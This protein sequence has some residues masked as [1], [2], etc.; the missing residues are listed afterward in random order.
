VAFPPAEHWVRRSSDSEALFP[1][2]AFHNADDTSNEWNQVSIS[3]SMLNHMSFTEQ[4]FSAQFP[5]SESEMIPEHESDFG[6]AESVESSNPAA[7]SNIPNQN[8]PSEMSSESKEHAPQ[9]S[10]FPRPRERRVDLAARRKR[11]RPAAIGTAGLSSSLRGPSS[12]SPTTRMPH[13][14]GLPLRH[15]KSTQNFSSVLSPR[16]PGIR[17]VSAS[18]RSPL[19]IPSSLES[20]LSGLSSADLTVPGLVPTTMAPP[21]PL[22][23]EDLRYLLPPTPGDGQYCLSPSHDI[24]GAP[25][26]TTPQSMQFHVQSPPMTPLHPTLTSH[27]QYHTVGGPLSAPARRTVFECF[28]VSEAPETSRKDTWTAVHGIHTSRSSPEQCIQMPQPVHISPVPYGEVFGEQN[29]QSCDQLSTHTSS[30]ARSMCNTRTSPAAMTSDLTPSPASQTMSTQL[31]IQPF[32][33]NSDPRLGSGQ[34]LQPQM[35]DM[36]AYTQQNLGGY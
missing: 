3:S 27:L 17:K 29:M 20:D 33:E 10:A 4:L 15:V 32:P 14:G 23:P 22:T 25:W 6:S 18:L 31:R 24:N 34:H 36:Y 11:P 26:Y 5:V 9:D 12:M 1:G 2:S 28:P 19:G 7:P 30:P 8:P 21:T 35:A 16:Y 13:G